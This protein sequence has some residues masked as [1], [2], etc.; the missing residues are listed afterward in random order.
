MKKTNILITSLCLG[1]ASLFCNNIAFAND[2]ECAIWLC[3]P[4]GFPPGCEGALKAMHKRLKH[5]KKPIPPMSS[6]SNDGEDHDTDT[7]YG[8]SAY[9]PYLKECVKWEERIVYGPQGPHKEKGS[10][11][12]YSEQK[13]IYIKN[14]SCYGSYRYDGWHTEPHGCTATVEWAE[15]YSEGQLV[16][17]TYNYECHAIAQGGCKGVNMY[18]EE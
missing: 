11:I 2:D 7:K 8:Y 3:L 6:C 14:R 4:A 17:D 5:H 12:E 1:V 10:C 18:S 13:H 15:V 16:G 9:I